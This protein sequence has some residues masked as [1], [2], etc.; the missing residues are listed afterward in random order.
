MKK[1]IYSLAIVGLALVS[2]NESN[3]QRAFNLSSSRSN[4]GTVS[5][6]EAIKA[7]PNPAASFTVISNL[8]DNVNY[9][10]TVFNASGQRV[11]HNTEKSVGSS[12]TVDLRTLTRGVY[13]IRVGEGRN[14][15]TVKV[16]KI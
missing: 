5:N 12:I 15:Q 14:F 9:E 6:F 4:A 3:A 10:I 8:M 13:W 2:I 1:L 11:I 16:L 7:S